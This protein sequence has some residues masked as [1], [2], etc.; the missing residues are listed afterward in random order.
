MISLR[1]FL[2]HNHARALIVDAGIFFFI[3]VD[4]LNDKCM[5]YTQ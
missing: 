2:L 1:F 4:T 3:S 5:Y